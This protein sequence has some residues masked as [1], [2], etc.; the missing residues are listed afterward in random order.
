MWSS[1][2][3]ISLLRQQ[4]QTLD[5]QAVRDTYR[6]QV[7]AAAATVVSFNCSNAMFDELHD[8]THD[9]PERARVYQSTTE[10]RPPEFIT[11]ISLPLRRCVR[12]GGRELV[13]Y[14]DRRQS[15]RAAAG[16]SPG[17]RGK[18]WAENLPTSTGPPARCG[19]NGSAEATSTCAAAGRADNAHL[20]TTLDVQRG[21]TSVEHIASTT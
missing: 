6:P 9:D 5:W 1:W 12:D 10:Q 16:D 8:T 21:V 19:A 7:Q 15:G 2:S 20:F 11:I 3:K 18:T 17:V 13:V 4:R 14:R